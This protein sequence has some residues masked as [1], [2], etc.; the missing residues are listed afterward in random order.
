MLSGYFRQSYSIQSTAVLYLGFLGRGLFFS[1]SLFSQIS[2]FPH[3]N[4]YRI[5]SADFRVRFFR[6][7]K[8]LFE[9]EDKTFA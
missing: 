5:T 7:Y 3:K 1:D 4:K 6:V 2:F 8:P 9:V